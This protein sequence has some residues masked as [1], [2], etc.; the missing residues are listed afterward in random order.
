LTAWLVTREP[1]EAERH[2]RRRRRRDDETEDETEETFAPTN[3]LE[4]D[5]QTLSQVVMRHS[6][7]NTIDWSDE[8]E[9][10]SGLP[11]LDR[12]V[13]DL[14]GVPLSSGELKA[15]V[16]ELARHIDEMTAAARNVLAAKQRGDDRSA[17]AYAIDLVRA[18]TA[19]KASSGK[20]A[21]LCPE[22]GSN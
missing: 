15:N 10:A 13:T 7:L 12:L 6:A 17:Q 11:L 20:I 8:R 9:V 16:D 18:D 3:T 2:R 22:D 14:R 1:S 19:M 5:C 21:M 4:T